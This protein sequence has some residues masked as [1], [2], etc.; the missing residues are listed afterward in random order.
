MNNQPVGH[1]TILND[2]TT[3]TICP[4]GLRLW[5]DYQPPP[6]QHVGVQVRKDLRK[7]SSFRQS[8]AIAR[9]LY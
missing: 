2:P 6:S 4:Y 1:L 7:R 3:D 5:R 9:Q 8:I